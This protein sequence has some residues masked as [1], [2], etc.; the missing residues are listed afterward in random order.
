MN[1]Y[2]TSK[3]RDGSV[4]ISIIIPM[5][6]SSAFLKD[7][8]DSV[9]AQSVENWELILVDDS[10][11]DSS[12]ELACCYAENDERIKCVRLMKNSGAAVA[13]NVAIKKAAGRFIAFLDAD[14]IWLPNKLEKQLGFM[15]ENKIPFSFSGYEK[16][17]EFGNVFGYVGVPEKVS[18]SELLKT[19]YI[20]CLT[21][22]YDTEY[23]GKVYMPEV[24]K[25]Q[26]FSLWLQL[27][28]KVDYAWGIKEPLAQYRIHSNSISANKLNVFKYTWRVYRD[29]EKLSLLKSFYYFSH[30]AIRGLLRKKCPRLARIVGVMH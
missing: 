21:A 6:N 30:Y 3:I 4:K 17:D 29:V 25:R 24:R 9:L 18:Y 28:K 16:V 19:C 11:T 22:M 1:G 10:S 12:Y 13:R 20:G 23:F 2:L 14:D 27:L 7:A 26:D 8:V 15:I 5:Y